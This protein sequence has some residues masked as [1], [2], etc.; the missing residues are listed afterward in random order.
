MAKDKQER[1]I[2]FSSKRDT[3]KTKNLWQTNSDLNFS[4]S[5][6][7][8]LLRYLSRESVHLFHT[9]FLLYVH[10]LTD[11]NLVYTKQQV[12]ADGSEIGC[13]SNLLKWY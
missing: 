12:C 13:P 5:Y 7:V 11:E 3:Y 9:V 6:L 1:L 2:N 8:C 4:G 10:F